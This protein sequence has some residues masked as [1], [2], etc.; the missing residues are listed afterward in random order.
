MK[1]Y[2]TLV[3]YVGFIQNN[4]IE[5]K[6]SEEFVIFTHLRITAA[7][8]DNSRIFVHIK[9]IYWNITLQPTLKEK[10]FR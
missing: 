4:K 6:S 9:Q 2:R 1:K 10:R 8:A 3:V 7:K 5:M